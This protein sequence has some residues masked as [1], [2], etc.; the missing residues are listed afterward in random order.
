[1]TRYLPVLLVVIIPLLL[2]STCDKH[3]DPLP[4]PV[5]STGGQSSATGGAL[6]TGGWENPSTGGTTSTGGAVGTGGAP[7]D[8]CEAA[9]RRLEALKCKRASDGGP[10]WLTPAGV[11][12]MIV[13][14]DHE[15]DKDSLCPRC[16]ATVATCDG[17]DLCRPKSPGVC[18]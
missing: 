16:M 1:M 17:V 8:D 18:P 7:A 15:R 6:G 10:R 11:S 4:G 12:F 3:V 13:C 9:A 2:A 5:P 14:R